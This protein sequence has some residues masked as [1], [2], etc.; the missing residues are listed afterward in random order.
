MTPVAWGPIADRGAPFLFPSISEIVPFRLTLLSRPAEKSF[1][2]SPLVPTAARQS[3]GRGQRVDASLFQ[4]GVMLM[5]YHL[6]FQQFTGTTP[7]P[8]GSRHTS[9]AP[10]GVFATGDGTIMI[11]ISNDRLF[12]RLCAA[13][14]KTEW[15]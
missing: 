3:S 8:Q 4:T 13:L 2:G 14:G 9:F 5:A 6:V 12:R 7:R 15:A 1:D 10:Y 11:G